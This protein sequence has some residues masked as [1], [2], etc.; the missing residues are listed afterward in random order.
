MTTTAKTVLYGRYESTRTIVFPHANP[1]TSTGTGQR[2]GTRLVP[3]KLAQKCS[4]EVATPR[5]LGE[6]LI[7]EWQ[8]T[9]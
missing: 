4:G 2:G 9:H 3:H 5:G 1:L 6:H 7:Y 8:I